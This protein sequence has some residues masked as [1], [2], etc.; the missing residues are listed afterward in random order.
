MV[1]RECVFSL[2]HNEDAWRDPAVGRSVDQIRG[3]GVRSKNTGHSQ[4]TLLATSA[5]LKYE[6]AMISAETA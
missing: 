5:L 1:S 6:I 2:H 3:G 4:V